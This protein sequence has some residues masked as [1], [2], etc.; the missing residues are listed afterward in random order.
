MLEREKAQS[1]IEV[2]LLLGAAVVVA[3]AIGFFLKSLVGS[4]GGEAN[5][6]G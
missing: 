6:I 4:I 1:S 5:K 2:L 3:A